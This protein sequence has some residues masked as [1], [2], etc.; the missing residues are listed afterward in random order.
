MCSSGAQ[1]FAT[2]SGASAAIA[3]V[4]ALVIPGVDPTHPADVAALYARHLPDA[5][6]V[7]TADFAAAIADFMDR[8]G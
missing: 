1:P 6:L 4:P 2:A 7:E 5:A 3:A 8:E